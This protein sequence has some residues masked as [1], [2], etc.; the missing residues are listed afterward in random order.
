M[1]S[2]YNHPN[3]VPRISVFA[4]FLSHIKVYNLIIQNNIPY[5]CVLEDDG[6]ILPV[7]P[8]ILTAAQ[9]VPWD[10]LMLSS[11]TNFIL[12]I[13]P[14]LYFLKFRIF[15]KLVHYRK[16]Y[17]Q[18]NPFTV[19]LLILKTLKFILQR[20]R[21]KML[22]TILP[23]LQPKYIT[24]HQNW[25]A[26]IWHMACEIGGLPSKDKLTWRKAPLSTTLP[27]HPIALTM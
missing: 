1:E 27:H 26:I 19:R 25:Q 14:E 17:P 11:Q 20:L 4:C 21:N 12:D 15:Y 13:L 18:L 16:Y 2:L 6:D 7:F 24:I 3:C 9:K 23:K 22:K 5:A 10:I 8:K